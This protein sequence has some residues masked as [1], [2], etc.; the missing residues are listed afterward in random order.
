M[1][2]FQPYREINSGNMRAMDY[3]RKT[4]GRVAP[5]RRHA[6]FTLMELMIAVAI[7][8]ILVGVAAPSMTDMLVNGRLQGASSDLVADLSLARG[9]AAAKGQR[10]TICQSSTGATSNPSCGG[11]STWQNG[12]IVFVDANGNGTFE[13]P[14]STPTA[15]TDVMIK[16]HEAMNSNVTV[17][18]YDTT[19]T[20]PTLNA[21]SASIVSVRYRPSGTTTA[22]AAF[23]FRVCQ[24]GFTFR[25]IVIS[26]QGR[27]SSSVSTLRATAQTS[28]SCS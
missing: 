12:W 2:R 15:G 20:P 5:S 8:A 17:A 25:D 7:V 21:A 24:T 1:Q 22:S 11:V 4:I 9:S 3:A 19:G 28:T 26:A 18:P 14:S 23:G 13:G 10:V 6:G 27:L 16:V